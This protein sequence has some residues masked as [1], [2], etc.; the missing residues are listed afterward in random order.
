MRA[1]VRWSWQR[2]FPL[3]LH[4]WSALTSRTGLPIHFWQE[5]LPYVGELDED[6]KTMAFELHKLLDHDPFDDVKPLSESENDMKIA[7]QQIVNRILNGD[8][9]DLG[10]LRPGTPPR[11][12]A[13]IE[14]CWNWNARP[15]RL[16]DTTMSS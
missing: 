10:L 8:H 1:S 9:P 11:M 4:P 6:Q 5:L 3:Q 12:K 2:N 15:E 14:S 7:A 13:L 16:A